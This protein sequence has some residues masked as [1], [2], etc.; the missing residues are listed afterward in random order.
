MMVMLLRLARDVRML[1]RRQVYALEHAKLG[2]Q[3]EIAENSRPTKTDTLAAGVGD[4]VGSSEVPV[5]ASDKIGDGS[6]RCRNAMAPGRNR[7]HQAA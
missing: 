7:G 6:A 5:T 4:Q 1:A 2:E 3:L